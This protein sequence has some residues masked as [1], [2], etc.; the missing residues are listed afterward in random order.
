MFWL[1]WDAAWMAEV[2]PD[3]VVLARDELDPARYSGTAG[4]VL[5]FLA[6]IGH[7][8]G[9]RRYARIRNEQDPYYAIAWPD[10]PPPQGRHDGSHD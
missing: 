5:A 1:S 10:H 9:R 6:A 7:V 8:A 2:C 4:I 3:G